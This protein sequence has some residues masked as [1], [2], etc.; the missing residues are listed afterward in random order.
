MA[1]CAV[2]PICVPV[3]GTLI[4]LSVEECNAGQFAPAIRLGGRGRLM[5]WVR[6]RPALAM[7]GTALGM[8]GMA[9]PPSAMVAAAMV[10][11]LLMRPMR[12]M[13]GVR[14]MRWVR[15]RLRVAAAI[16]RRDRCF[17][18]FLDVA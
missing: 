5:R 7:G 16:G 11:F 4:A 14:L 1:V 18:Q 10:L 3:G 13:A 17:D 15:P 12:L 6:L 8:T 2:R 9:L